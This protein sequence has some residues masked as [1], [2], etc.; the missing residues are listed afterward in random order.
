ME[1]HNLL[2]VGQIPF[3][4]NRDKTFSLGNDNVFG[5]EILPIYIEPLN[6]HLIG[7][8]YSHSNTNIIYIYIYIH[9]V[10]MIGPVVC[11]GLEA[12]SKDA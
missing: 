10:G 3:K 12:R 2:L 8:I 4:D 1:I 6:V 5:K 11:I 9:T 7:N